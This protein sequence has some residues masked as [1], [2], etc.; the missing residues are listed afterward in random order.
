MSEHVRDPA[1]SPRPGPADRPP[2]RPAPAARRTW[3]SAP[4]SSTRPSACSP[5]T[6]STASAWTRSR[7]RPASPSSPS[8]A[9][10]ATRR[11]CSPR[12]MQAHVRATAA[13]LAVRG[14]AGRAAARAAAADRA[15]VLRAD[16]SPEA[17]AG[18]RDH[19]HRRSSSNRPMLGSCSGTPAR[20]AV[21]EA[22]ER[23]C[24]TTIAAGELRDRR[25]APRRLAVLLPAQGRAAR[26][27]GVRLR[28][29]RRGRDEVE[30]ARW[31][32]TVDLFLRAYAT[33]APANAPGRA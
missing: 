27:P 33:P 29:E 22:F 32:A 28:P 7:P 8:T 10:S 17:L 14:R 11:R 21:Q 3:A 31:Q 18:H 19:V 1:K 4:R 16:H 12:P 24:G 6:A 5:R 9:I 2:S 30:A 23:S 15:R 20:S 25:R 26:A 13:D